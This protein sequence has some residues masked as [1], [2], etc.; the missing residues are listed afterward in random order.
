MPL[1]YIPFEHYLKRWISDE[2]PVNETGE[3]EVLEHNVYVAT[4][5]PVVV[6]QEIAYLIAAAATAAT[7]TA[8]YHD[9]NQR[10]DTQLQQ[11]GQTHPILLVNGCHQL[12]FYFNPT[13]EKSFHI[14]GA[15]EKTP[16][17]GDTCTARYNRNIASIADLWMLARSRAFIG[18][19]NSNWGRLLRVVRL[20]LTDVDP[21]S[22][23]LDMRIAWGRDDVGRPGL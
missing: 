21:F 12:T 13:Q 2:C 23:V 7:A 11:T 22:V 5:D 6:K 3:I 14:A 4:D 16:I 15:G 10:P 8:N 19:F 17:E 1:D 9:K 18:E 20:R